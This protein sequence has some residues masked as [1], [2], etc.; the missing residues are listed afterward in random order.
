M[1]AI[2]AGRSA[3]SFQ[4]PADV[5]AGRRRAA[6]PPAGIWAERRLP[7]LQLPLTGI[8]CGLAFSIL[9][10]MLFAWLVWIAIR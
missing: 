8:G 7:R 6:A 10:W 3:T 9:M 2:Y 5:L 4:S 1:D